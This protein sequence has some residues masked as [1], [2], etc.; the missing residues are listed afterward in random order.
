LL[1]LALRQGSL[2]AIDSVQEL[3]LLIRLATRM[4]RSGRVL[5]RCRP[6]SQ[7]QMSS[8]FGMTEAERIN[9][10]G[11]CLNHSAEI[12]MEGFAFHLNGYSAKQRADMAGQLIDFCLDARN[13]GLAC[14]TVN[15]GGGFAVRYAAPA[16]WAHFLKVQTPLDYH[17]NKTFESFY[18]YGAQ[19]AGASMLAE[20]LETPGVDGIGLGL[21]MRQHGIRLLLEPGRALLDQ[22]GFSVFRVQ[23][24]KDR[25]V[26]EGYAILTVDG[27]S[28]SLSEQWFNS[29]YLPDPLL[30]GASRAVD[31]SIFNACVGGSSCLDSDMLTWRKIS[32]PRSVK[33]GDLLLY[34]NTAGY[35]MDSNESPFHDAP[36]PRKVV[37]TFSDD[38]PQWRLDEVADWRVVAE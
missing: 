32:F 25:H 24:V 6:D 36:L 29:E 16:K 1:D 10:L 35:Q 14:S 7:N 19:G 9:A 21:R 4:K 17:A 20:I 5:L 27:M 2:I 37:V 30:L 33:A 28:F 12:S 34:A 11:I 26:R 18:P 13:A 23:G 38:S 8:R 15:I 31:G 22:A 3:Q